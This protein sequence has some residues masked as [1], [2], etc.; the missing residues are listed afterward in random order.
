MSQVFGLIHPLFYLTY[1][2]VYIAD[3]HPPLWL[4]VVLSISATM[5]AAAEASIHGALYGNFSRIH[6][7]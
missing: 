5:W 7:S 2:R 3:S 6:T 1:G 4:L